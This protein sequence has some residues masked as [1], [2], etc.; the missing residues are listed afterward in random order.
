MNT[1]HRKYKYTQPQPPDSSPQQPHTAESFGRSVPSPCRY[2][3]SC[4]RIRRGRFGSVLLCED[5]VDHVR[6]AFT[7]RPRL[8]QPHLSTRGD[9]ADQEQRNTQ[10]CGGARLRKRFAEEMC[11]QRIECE[12]AKA[13]DLDVLV[14]GIPQET[15]GHVCG[16]SSAAGRSTRAH[17]REEADAAR[18]GRREKRGKRRKRKPCLF[19]TVSFSDSSTRE[20]PDSDFKWPKLQVREACARPCGARSLEIV[21]RLHALRGARESPKRP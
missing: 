4:V 14:F 15:S 7:Q 12:G 8:A 17:R 21:R 3:F 5:S 6:L 18:E 1:V 16:L 2:E 9:R 13:S 20:T 19:E 10:L 11:G